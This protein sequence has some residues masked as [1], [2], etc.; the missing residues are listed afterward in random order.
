M[1]EFAC[2]GGPAGVAGTGL[3]SGTVRITE[4]ANGGGHVQVDIEGSVD[5]YEILGGDP[6]NPQLG[7]YVAT[8]TYSAHL[9]EEAPPGGTEVQGGNWHG[10]IVFAD[11]RTAQLSIGFSF[12]IGKDGVKLFN[13]RGTC[14]GE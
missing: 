3:E 1:G 10:P 5:L 8:W 2:D 7:A 6:E 9:K 14:S 4:T 11:G 12:V 13:A